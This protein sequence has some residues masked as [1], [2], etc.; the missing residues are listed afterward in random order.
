MRQLVLYIAIAFA[1]LFVGCFKDEEYKTNIVLRCYQ[2]AYSGDS[3]VELSGV[4]AHSFTADTTDYMVA[5]YD[6]ALAGV[7]TN[8]TSGSKLSAKYSSQAWPLEDFESSVAVEAEGDLVVLVVVDTEHE[9]YAYRNYSMGLNLETTYIALQFR[10]WYEGE[11]T[12]NS[13]QY[14]VPEAI[15]VE[16]EE[17]EEESDEEESDEENSDEEDEDES[18]SEEESEEDGSFDDYDSSDEDDGSFDN[19]GSS[20]EEDSDTDTEDNTTAEE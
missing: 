1:T 11:F 15:I 5:S 19:Y 18:E 14:V 17:E 8:R 2:Q 13:W 6:D 3:Y 7:L 10:P 20:D 4:V 16:V 9:D 12:Q